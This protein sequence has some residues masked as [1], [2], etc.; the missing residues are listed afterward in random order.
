MIDRAPGSGGQRV[1]RA[2]PWCALAIVGLAGCADRTHVPQ[3]LVL[4]AERYAPTGQPH[5]PRPFGRAAG[6]GL[7]L[8]TCES[9]AGW[10]VDWDI[11]PETWRPGGAPGFFEVPHPVVPLAAGGLGPAEAVVLEVAGHPLERVEWSAAASASPVQ[12]GSYALLP[13]TLVLYW[14]GP[15]PAARLSVFVSHGHRE[16]ATWRVGRPGASGEGFLLPAG[17]RVVF[18]LDL[19][20]GATLRLGLGDAAGGPAARPL[21]LRVRLNGRAVGIEPLGE[22][23]LEAGAHAPL[24]PIRRVELPLGGERHRA[25]RLELEGLGERGFLQVLAPSVGPPDGAPDDGRP[26]IVLFVADTLRADLLSAYRGA[27]AGTPRPLLPSVDAFADSAA[28]FTRAFAPSSWTL[29]SHASLFTGLTPEQHGA[30]LPSRRLP[31]ELPSVTQALRAAGYRTAAATD[32]AFLA[33]E[34]GLDRGFEW[35]EYD[36]DF[37]QDREGMLDTTVARARGHLAAN[38][39]RPLF[40]FLHTFRV[41]TPYFASPQALARLLPEERPEIEYDDLWTRTELR[42][43][44]ARGG[45]EGRRLELWAKEQMERMYWAGALDLDDGFA[46]LI[47]LLEARARPAAIVFTSDHGES[48]RELRHHGHLTALDEDQTRIPLVLRAP[49]LA[50]GRIDTPVDLTDLAPTLA[51]LGRAS[52]DLPGPGRSLLGLLEAAPRVQHLELPGGALRA[53]VDWPHRLTF[54]AAGDV[55]ESDLAADPL[56]TQRRRLD[57]AGAEGERIAA[58]RAALDDWPARFRADPEDANL[59]AGLLE[60][61]RAL[62]YLTGE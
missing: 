8:R 15:A 12:S 59:S 33:A 22:G 52:W 14:E 51:Y 31:A 18:E 19:E 25:A 27:P 3:P 7:S 58:A 9:G 16:H 46:E 57:P 11:P 6:G 49:G 44:I 45:E 4:L 39:G 30:V 34:Y 40:L 38:D 21:A 29:P 37:E 5:L 62:G 41:H 24:V 47:A 26:D 17:E 2:A 50:P 32:G 60:Q 36:L 42:E 35:F 55:W 20:P 28:I 53:L 43:R 13:F 54:E 10:W 23:H 1:G 61:L 48:F 56:E